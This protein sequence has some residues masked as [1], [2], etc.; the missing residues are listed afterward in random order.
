MTSLL[1]FPWF[2]LIKFLR[3]VFILSNM[4]LLILPRFAGSFLAGFS[5]R[6]LS[7]LE[8]FGLWSLKVI[9]LGHILDL[10]CVRLLNAAHFCQ[11]YAKL[12]SD[13]KHLE[14]GLNR[15]GVLN[16]WGPFSKKVLFLIK[17]SFLANIEHC[18]KFLEYALQ[19][20]VSVIHKRSV[21]YFFVSYYFFH[22]H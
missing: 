4:D 18:P 8:K 5:E 9:K 19:A 15:G 20:T 17:V 11:N 1:S 7:L 13:A 21:D 16:F 12:H 3:L 14:K 6:I 2:T 10:Y 22:L